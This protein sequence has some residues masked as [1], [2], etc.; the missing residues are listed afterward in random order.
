MGFPWYYVSFAMSNKNPLILA[1]EEPTEE[2]EGKFSPF[3]LIQCIDSVHID[4]V[5][6]C[7]MEWV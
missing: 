2:G 7:N 4:P 6:I 1:Q 3:F 5:L